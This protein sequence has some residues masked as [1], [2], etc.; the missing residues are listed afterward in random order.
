MDDVKL[1][2][3]KFSAEYQDI[4]VESPKLDI[5]DGIR[6]FPMR[7]GIY[8]DSEEAKASVYPSGKLTLLDGRGGAIPV[9]KGYGYHLSPMI[10]RNGWLYVYSHNTKS[11]YIYKCTNNKYT[12]TGIKKKDNA[13]T[14]KDCMEKHINQTNDFILL[15][16]DDVVQLFYTSIELSDSFINETYYNKQPIGSVFKCK[17]WSD[18]TTKSDIE[19]RHVDADSI[20][21]MPDKTVMPEDGYANAIAYDYERLIDSVKIQHQEKRTKF[22]DVFFVLDDPLGCVEKLI[23]DLNDARIEHESLIRSI[24]TGVS[25]EKIK[26]LLMKSAGMQG[27]ENEE[28]IYLL[29]EMDLLQGKDFDTRKEEI[30]QAQ[31]IHTLLLYFYNF[32][33]SKEENHLKAGAKAL[34]R[35]SIEKLLATEERKESRAKI[36]NLRKLIALYINS[37]I[38]TR[39]CERFTVDTVN[40]ASDENDVMHSEMKFKLQ[41][42]LMTILLALSPVPHINDKGLDLPDAYKKYNDP[43]ASTI[44]SIFDAFIGEGDDKVGLLL[45]DIPTL[46]SLNL[47]IARDTNAAYKEK[48][49]A[50][51]DGSF[52]AVM[53]LLD[54]A[55]NT[56]WRIAYET[57][58][59]KL[60]TD[61]FLI[62]W[63]NLLIEFDKGDVTRR[64]NEIGR[65]R[66]D[67]TVIDGRGYIR[68]KV[69][70]IEDLTKPVYIK[71]VAKNP[72][73]YQKFFK[74]MSCNKSY[75]A[76]F[77]FIQL[78]AIV[79]GYDKENEEL[80]TLVQTVGFASAIATI[81]R[82]F[83]ETG[84]DLRA[85]VSNRQALIY[86]ASL[87]RIRLQITVLGA[88][89]MFADAATAV[90]DMYTRLQRNDKDAAT[91]YF[92]SAL[93][94]ATGGGLALLGLKFAWAGGPWTILVCAV[95]GFVCGIIA[96]YLID[97]DI[98]TFIKRTVLYED[99]TK[100]LTGEPYQQIQKLSSVATR[101]NIFYDKFYEEEDTKHLKVLSDYRYQLEAF[102]YTQAMIPFFSAKI[103]YR[104]KEYV[105]SADSRVRPPLYDEVL[106]HIYSDITQIAMNLSGIKMRVRFVKKIPVGKNPY[107][108]VDLKEVNS[109]SQNNIPYSSYFPGQEPIMTDSYYRYTFQDGNLANTFYASPKLYILLYVSFRHNDGSITPMPRNGK[110]T[111]LIYRY[112]VDIPNVP[113]DSRRLLYHEAKTILEQVFIS[114]DSKDVWNF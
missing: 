10:L 39:L 71:T 58:K 60:V 104:R 63:N 93:S 86:Q 8:C 24:Q 84:L 78:S 6:L 88:I 34:D 15:L 85:S 69:K 57:K 81:Q 108:D 64:L 3:Y 17:E 35:D 62:D 7:F 50:G 106:V 41:S 100:S 2:S 19:R 90:F 96:S 83:I 65:S 109:K 105:Y 44:K 46:A 14:K 33:Y 56:F 98:E 30:K 67:E 20:W 75:L 28:I 21:F 42:S 82:R 4:K 26:R 32:A 43:C 23:H 38:F 101:S 74:R 89:G 16:S 102:L 29:S 59:T 87:E 51:V 52:S 47:D 27:L 112:K 11:V 110:E 107:F 13:S 66:L 79:E 31:Y 25:P 36:E 111:F 54:N 77:S 37:P 40:I 73:N 55:I 68:I 18:G 5:I 72:K 22:R 103:E 95:I 49:S 94:F 12:L 97:S 61:R 70:K 99:I 92:I 113:L 9:V 80:K 76:I 1:G 48:N 91:F 45:K 53:L 114:P